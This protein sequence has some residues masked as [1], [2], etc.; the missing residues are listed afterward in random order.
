MTIL[1]YI[2]NCKVR[3]VSKRLKASKLQMA[4]QVPTI[5]AASPNYYWGPWSKTLL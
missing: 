2:C 5:A 3:F 1:P 4:V